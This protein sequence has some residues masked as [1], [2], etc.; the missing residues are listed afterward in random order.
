MRREERKAEMGEE[1]G[2]GTNEQSIPA[3]VRN[4]TCS[5]AADETNKGPCLFLLVEL[6]GHLLTAL[7]ARAAKEIDIRDSRGV[8]TRLCLSSDNQ[9]WRNPLLLG[10]LAVRWGGLP[11]L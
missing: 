6:G 8:E 11:S 7:G 5:L 1:K 9:W 3:K 10:T 4:V 2:D